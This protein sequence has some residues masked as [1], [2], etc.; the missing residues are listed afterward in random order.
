ML[1]LTRRTVFVLGVLLFGCSS[2]ESRAIVADDLVGKWAIVSGGGVL[3]DI[4]FS[5]EESAAA[6]LR[7]IG[8]GESPVPATFSYDVKGAELIPIEADGNTGAPL[9]VSWEND[10]RLVL[11]PS[12]GGEMV[13]EPRSF[14][15]IQ[16]AGRR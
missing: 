3:T 16:P 1:R 9:T 12:A 13:L 11:A 4:E 14:S 8:R 7:L 6:E 5:L 15:R 2:R 10:G